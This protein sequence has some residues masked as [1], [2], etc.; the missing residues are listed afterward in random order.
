MTRRLKT[1]NPFALF[2]GKFNL[3]L[4]WL[5]LNHVSE[6]VH[7][8]ITSGTLQKGGNCFGRLTGSGTSAWDQVPLRKCRIVRRLQGYSS[9]RYRGWDTVKGKD[10]AWNEIYVAG[11]SEK[12]K[13]RFSSEVELLRSIDDDHFIKY[14]S[15][16]YDPKEE[17]VII[18]TQ[19]V[20][21]G[22]LNKWISLS[23]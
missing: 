17:K 16:W 15:S 8:G 12:E 18:I 3:K 11:L 22:T 2:V 10:V 4:N 13:E 19:I 21:S 9:S 23:P 6:D 7:R 20:N 1:C 14:Y 5:S